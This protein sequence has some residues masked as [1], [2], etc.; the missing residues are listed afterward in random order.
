MAEKRVTRYFPATC[1]DS[2][3]RFEKA[4]MKVREKWPEAEWIPGETDAGG[5]CAFD[6]ISAQARFEPQ[7]KLILSSG[8]HGIEG[9]VGS[10][11]LALFVDEFMPL[12]DEDDT[13]LLMIH[14]INAAGMAA[15]RRTN[16]SNVD[17][18]RNFLNSEDEFSSRCNPDYARI[19]KLINPHAKLRSKFLANT[20]FAAG[21]LA[22]ILVL[23]QARMQRALLLGQYRFPRGVYYGGDAFQPETVRFRRIVQAQTEGYAEVVFIDIHTG[24]GPR[25]RMTLVNSPLEEEP[26]G[27]LETLFN[28]A[29][30]TSLGSDTFYQI[31]GDMLDHFY[32]SF[33]EDNRAFFATAFEFGTLGDSLPAQLRSMRAIVLENQMRQ[34]GTTNERIAEWVVREFCELFAPSDE[35]WREKALEDARS[36]FQGILKG[37]GFI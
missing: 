21:L 30:V 27:L 18:N 1:L 6:A 28:Y 19:V 36:A 11:V 33:A 3:L 24:Y 32:A 23:G 25:G 2:R 14:P 10:A 22:S 16:A 26:P 5:I 13:G 9:F 17:L 12:I 15:L 29:P 35:S 4:L 20:R 31:S 7:H 37:K 8:L 34:F